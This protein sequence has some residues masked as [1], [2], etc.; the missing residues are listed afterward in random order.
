MG[1]QEK[2]GYPPIGEFQIYNFKFEIENQ[3]EM[4]NQPWRFA[5]ANVPAP[6]ISGQYP[7]F[8]ACR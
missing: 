7:H 4:K 8:R 5:P 6:C 1:K 3:F 2:L